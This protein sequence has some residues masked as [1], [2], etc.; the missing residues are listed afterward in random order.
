MGTVAKIKQLVKLPQDTVRVLV[1]GL[2]RGRLDALIKEEPFMAAE[3]TIFQDENR[4]DEIHGAA[5][6]R[7]LR[8]QLGTYASVNSQFSA[9][10]VRK[11]GK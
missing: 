1:E 10:L 4:P 6:V 2:F 7:Y 8:N 5:M 9:E 11:L 3:V